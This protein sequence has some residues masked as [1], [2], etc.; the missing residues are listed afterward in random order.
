MTVRHR[1]KE[2]DDAILRPYGAT[3]RVCQTYYGDE[4][5]I[6]TV[7]GMPEGIGKT[8]YVHHS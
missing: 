8:G 1:K 2:F 7:S 6:A 5:E 4:C 3:H